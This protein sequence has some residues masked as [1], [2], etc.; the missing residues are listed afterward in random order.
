MTDGSTER[1]ERLRELTLFLLAVALWCVTHPY[2]GMTE[3]DGRVYT[4]L[5]QHWLAPAAYARDPF[6]LFGSQDSFSIF[7]PLYGFLAQALGLAQGAKV[8]TALGGLLW[9]VAAFAVARCLLEDRRL[10]AVAVLCTVVWS[11]NYSPNAGTFVLNEAFPTAR[12]L[13]FP[14]AALAV[15][16]A[17]RDRLHVAVLLG[18]GA[19]AVHPLLGFWAVLVILVQRLPD[20]VSLAALLSMPVALFALHK[21]GVQALQLMEPAWESIA[22]NSSR[23]VFV[24]PWGRARINE[25][26][27]W[28]SLLLWAGRLAPLAAQRWYQ[29]A[30]LVSASGFLLAQ[31]SAYFLPLTLLIQAQSWRAVWIAMFLGVFALAQLLGTAW[32]VPQRIWFAIAGLLFVVIKDWCGFVLFGAWLILQPTVLTHLQALARRLDA[33]GRSYAPYLL[34]GLLLAVI[35]GYVQDL[36]MLGN[37]L[38]TDFQSGLPILDGLLLAG[39]WGVGALLLSFCV[40]PPIPPWLA[41]VGSTLVL[42]FAVG[43]WDQRTEGYRRWETFPQELA[44]PVF[45]DWIRPGE[46]VLWL[47][48]LPQRTWHELGTANYASSD[49]LIGG[50]FSRAKTFE[51]LRRRQRLAVGA[52]APS[53][54]V[55]GREESLLLAEYRRRFGVSLDE[56]GNLHESYREITLSGPGMLYVC[57]DPSL[58][59]VISEKPL[60]QSVLAAQ[61]V[62]DPMNGRGLNLYSCQRLRSDKA[63]G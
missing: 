33:K 2:V 48:A 23:D 13:G 4:L 17:M 38:A 8:I 59:W 32:R 41:L 28:L 19:T 42:A 45:S 20:R 35:P 5:V 11:L 37:G 18:L 61:A 6:F 57:E 7:T 15:A 60:V 27:A 31:L 25:I 46:V 50:I 51:L 9:V 29:A 43:H 22:R 49:Q 34:A 26:L 12:M 24:G 52:L 47:D 40:R 54:P 1:G 53:W 16:S 44:R 36:V 3:H 21:G 30:A 58:D 39:G 56:T 14:L 10:Q 63:K 62:R 55:S